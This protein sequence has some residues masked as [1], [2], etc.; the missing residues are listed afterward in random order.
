METHGS[1]VEEAPPQAGAMP[2]RIILVFLNGEPVHA[3]PLAT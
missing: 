1:G 3:A 2:T